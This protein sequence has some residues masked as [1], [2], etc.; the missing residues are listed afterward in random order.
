M[1]TNNPLE[2]EEVLTPEVSLPS[3]LC[4]TD[5]SPTV[6]TNGKAHTV[7]VNPPPAEASLVD[8]LRN[9][10]VREPGTGGKGNKVQTNIPVRTPDKQWFFRAHPDPKMA[11]EID[12]IEIHGGDDEGVWFLD[13]RVEFQDELDQ[14]IVPAIITRCITSDNIEFFYL[15]K[16][17]AK[18]P[19][20]STRRC[21]NEAKKAWIKQNWSPTA[22][23]YQF[24]YANQMRRNPVWSN[25]S[26]DDLLLKAVGE[27]LICDPT[28]AVIT[29]LLD[30]EDGEMGEE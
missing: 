24:Q 7:P 13:P 16:Q 9:K 6:P 3:V 11:L 5:I 27:R 8:A 21:I 15:A 18:S 23:G 28:H 2:E 22:K 17:S 4:E 25:F 26:L 19:K 12:I 14:Y 1:R 29:R 30:P 10:R 20:D